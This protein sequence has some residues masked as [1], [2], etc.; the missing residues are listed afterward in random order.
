M[1]QVRAELFKLPTG[2]RERGVGGVKLAPPCNG[3]AAPLW[4][5]VFRIALLPGETGLGY[6]LGLGCLSVIA[7]E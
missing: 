1:H 4:I 7:S 5:A 2:S 3:K 6:C